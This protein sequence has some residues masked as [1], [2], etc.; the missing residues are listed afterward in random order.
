M[1]KALHACFETIGWL[2]VDGFPTEERLRARLFPLTPN[3]DDVRRAIR[4][5]KEICETPFVRTLL[6]RSTY[7]TCVELPQSFGA[8]K[9][10]VSRP[11]NCAA[12]SWEVFRERPFSLLK[13]GENLW[14]GTIDRLVVLR[15]AGKVVG[16]EIVDF[17]TDRFQFAQEFAQEFVRETAPKTAVEAPE[18]AFPSAS[19]FGPS[20]KAL[21][22]Y[23]RQL[24]IYG[25]VVSHWYSLS[26]ERIS[27]R[28]AF[29][30]EGLA[31]DASA[32]TQPLDFQ[33]IEN[34]TF[35]MSEQGGTR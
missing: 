28:L 5:F 8:T 16:A 14:R 19:L 29:V 35:E 22:E 2:D 11:E 7:E 34:Q 4:R 18:K 12:P 26:P 10:A 15:D 9:S 24:S 20:P 31:I 23:R 1:G 17:K 13:P 33:H 30:S 21:A 32:Q 6:S 3:A 25:D 27:T